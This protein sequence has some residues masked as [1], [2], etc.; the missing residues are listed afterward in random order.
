[1]SLGVHYFHAQVTPKCCHLVTLLITR[2]CKSCTKCVLLYAQETYG[3]AFRLLAM[4]PKKIKT[5]RLSP[6]DEKLLAK[7][8]KK[9]GLDP[10]N[11]IRHA[12]YRLAESEGI[13]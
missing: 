11:V 10:T 7:L 13:H 1:M 12:I 8:S 3:H 5:I 9:L 4:A 2:V 6:L